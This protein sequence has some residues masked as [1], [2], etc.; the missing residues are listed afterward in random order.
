MLYIKTNKTIQKRLFKLALL[1]A[2]FL[3]RLFKAYV[4]GYV[5]NSIFELFRKVLLFYVAFGIV[6]RVLILCALRPDFCIAEGVVF[7]V[8]GH[9]VVVADV[10]R[11]FHC[12]VVGR[13]GGVA[14]GG[15]RKHRLWNWTGE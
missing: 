13:A 14:F 2:D 3:H 15:L 6:V 11:V 1:P 5:I 7:E 10:L 12:G 4:L 9:A 8:C